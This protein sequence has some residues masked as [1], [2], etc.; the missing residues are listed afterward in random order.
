MKCRWQKE[1]D[2][3]HWPEP[4]QNTHQSSDEDP[5]KAEQ[6]VAGLQGNLKTHGYA[7]KKIH[8]FFFSKTPGTLGQLSLQPHLENPISAQSRK[9]APG[10]NHHPSL[11]LHGFQ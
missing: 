10:N 5:D 9:E 8:P 4:R 11:G 1:R 6:K 3:R 2:G 7:L